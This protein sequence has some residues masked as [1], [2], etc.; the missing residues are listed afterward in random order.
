[1]IV[2]IYNGQHEVITRLARTGK[3]RRQ[4]HYSYPVPTV[5]AATHHRISSTACVGQL[6]PATGTILPL[7]ETLRFSA[8]ALVPQLG[9][10]SGLETHLSSSQ[11]YRCFINRAGSCRR[12]ASIRG[13]PAVV[14]IGGQADAR[15]K[16]S[17]PSRPGSSTR[18]KSLRARGFH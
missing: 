18:A 6:V 8:L 17:H 4:V 9:P 15:W 11:L 13:V 2:F 10:A 7:R 1:M 16:V 12:S 5:W 14:K 3:I